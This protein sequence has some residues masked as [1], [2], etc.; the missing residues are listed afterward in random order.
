MSHASSNLCRGV[1]FP[2]TTHRTLE[3]GNGAC[4]L[5]TTT[6]AL[7]AVGRFAGGFLLST[8]WYASC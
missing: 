8:S 2:P 7:D 6:L 1:T 5:M 4:G 3:I